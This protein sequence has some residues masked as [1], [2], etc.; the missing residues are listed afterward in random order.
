M[1]G[2]L[3]V[4]PIVFGIVLFKKAKERKR[5]VQYCRSEYSIALSPCPTL[6]S[7]TYMYVMYIMYIV[8]I[9]HTVVAV[10]HGVL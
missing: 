9:L 8:Y 10:W 3:V 4:V 5:K 6:N 7:Y 1:L 2:V